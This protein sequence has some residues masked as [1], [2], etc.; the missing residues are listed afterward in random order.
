MDGMNSCRDIPLPVLLFENFESQ[1]NDARELPS[2]PQMLR[3]VDGVV[4][5]RN[6]GSYGKF[7]VQEAESEFFH[8]VTHSSLFTVFFSQQHFTKVHYTIILIAH[9]DCKQ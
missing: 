5:D 9:V 3:R 6:T 8:K 7:P 4:D 1:F 2:L